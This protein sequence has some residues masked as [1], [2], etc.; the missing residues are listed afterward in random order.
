M[1]LLENLRRQFAYDAWANGE[2]LAA[3]KADGAGL[4]A[5]QPLKLLA[6]ILSA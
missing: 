1:Y 3:I 4:P 2:V 6:H 5:A